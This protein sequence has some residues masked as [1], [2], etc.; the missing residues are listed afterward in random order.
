MITQIV[1]NYATGLTFCLQS[2]FWTPALLKVEP[3]F[4]WQPGLPVPSPIQPVRGIVVKVKDG[5]EK[6]HYHTLVHMMHRIP[7][8]HLINTKA[9]DRPERVEDQMTARSLST[10]LIKPRGWPRNHFLGLRMP[11]HNRPTPGV[12]SCNLIVYSLTMCCCG[13]GGG[14]ISAQKVHL[15]DPAPVI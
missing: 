7:H 2:L 6:L 1:M 4:F 3:S 8:A 14:I 13:A 10:T 9:L 5:L 12:V 15:L 11:C